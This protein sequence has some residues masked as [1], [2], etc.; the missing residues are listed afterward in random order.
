MSLINT[1]FSA[2]EDILSQTVIGNLQQGANAKTVE[3]VMAGDV[4]LFDIILLSEDSSRVY[5][6]MAQATAIDIYESILSPVIFC[7]ITI[8]DSIGLLQSFPILGEEYITVIFNTPSNDQQVTYNFRVYGIENKQ[9]NE[10]NKRLTYTLKCVSSELATNSGLLITKKADSE[11]HLVVAEILQDDLRSRKPVTV[12]PTKGIENVLI[13]KMQP[14][15]AIDFLR[16]RAVSSRFTSSSFCFF[17][18]RDGYFFTTIEAM[19]SKGKQQLQSGN[20]DKIFFFDTSRKD[21]IE[22]ITIRNILAYNHIS[23][24]DTITTISEGGL[25]NQVQSFDLIT[26]NIRRLTYTDNIGGDLFVQSSDNS[27][28]TNSS[29]FAGGHGKTT[30]ITRLVPIR[31]DKPTTYVPEKMSAVQA[32]AQKIIQN[33]VQIHVYGDSDITVGKMIQCNFPSAVDADDGSGVSRL[34]SG[35]YLVAKARH[36]ILIGDRPQYTMALELIKGDMEDNR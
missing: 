31:T 36:M 18:N 6:I 16:Q 28:S 33:I 22:N 10:S 13:T 24:G 29:Q 26:G 34:D 20:N 11:I 3:S 14:F 17:E 9:V 1:V 25:N 4:D 21:S 30:S 8:A 32:Y 23:L 2:V 5:S 12:D 15:R 19:I 27:S 7:E 35:N